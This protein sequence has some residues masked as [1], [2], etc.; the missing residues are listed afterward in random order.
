[1]PLLLRDN[2]TYRRVQIDKDGTRDVF[3][4]AS[5]GEEGLER[6]ALVELLRI[7]VRTAVRLEAVLKQVPV[8]VASI[9]IRGKRVVFVYVQLPG[10]VSELGSVRPC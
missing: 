2:A 7:G 4:A 6:S 1:L 8:K 9:R 5:L 3:A 10:A